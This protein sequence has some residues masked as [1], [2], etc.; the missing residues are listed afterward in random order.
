MRGG[1]VALL[2]ITVI[3]SPILMDDTSAAD[4]DPA[5]VYFFDKDGY[6]VAEVHLLPGTPIRAEDIPWH[7]AYL[8]WYDEDEVHID[9]RRVYQGVTFSSGTHI[10]RA[11]PSPP[12][13]SG[14]SG[15]SID[16]G[17]IALVIAVV[18]LLAIGYLMFRS[19]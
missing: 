14:D 8:D 18:D 6:C 4:D 19:K 1:I 17:M 5:F 10:V 11:L 13:P 2:A 9:G 15:T 12:T 3:L 7:G 16:L